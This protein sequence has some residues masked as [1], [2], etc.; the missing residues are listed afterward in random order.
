MVSGAGGHDRWI[1]LPAQVVGE[2]QCAISATGTL[3][4]RVGRKAQGA[5]P[6]ERCAD[7][8]ARRSLAASRPGGQVIS[9]TAAQG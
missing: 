8:V 4:I 1:N 7:A 5:T 6:A 2:A 3:V 9:R